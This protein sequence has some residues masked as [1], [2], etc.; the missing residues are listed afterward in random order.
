M[1]IG[2]NHDKLLGLVTVAWICSSPGVLLPALVAVPASGCCDCAGE[3]NDLWV[4]SSTV[5][6]RLD[7]S[8]DGCE[9]TTDRDVAV[10]GGYRQFHVELVGVGTCHLTATAADGRQATT[11][12]KVSFKRESCC[13]NYYETDRHDYTGHGGDGVQITFSNASPDG[14]T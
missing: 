9:K 14:G 4:T 3:Y 6:S 11:D 2:R 5:M 1:W 7:V 8:G 12:V 13:G 10:D